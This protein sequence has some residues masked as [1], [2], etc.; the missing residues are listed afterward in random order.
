MSIPTNL[1]LS[2]V[3]VGYKMARELPRTIRSLSPQ[4]Q[5]GIDAADY[6]IIVVDNGSPCPPDE[7]DVRQWS[8]NARLIV[9]E[10]ATASPVAAINRGLDEA[11]GAVIG[12]FIDGARMASPGLLSAALGA[13]QIHPRAVVGTLAFHLGPDVQMRSVHAGYDQLVEDAL[14]AQCRWEEDPYHLF[15]ISVFAGSSAQGWFTL[16]SETNALFLHRGHWRE[17]GG[18]DSRFI[19]PGGGLANLDIWE[20]LCS[21]PTARIIMLLGEA[22]FHQFHGGIATNNPQ[23]PWQIF[24]DEYVALRGKPFTPPQNDPLLVGRLPPAAKSSF[25]RSVAI[26]THTI[27]PHPRDPVARPCSIATGQRGFESCIPPELLAGIQNGVLHSR[28][29]DVPFLKSPFDIA[30]Y[31]QF[32][33]RKNFHT[34]IEIGSKFGGSALWFADLMSNHGRDNPRVVCV[35]IKPL[36]S[37]TDDRIIVLTGDA[38]NLKAC[39]TSDLLAGLRHPWLVVEDSSHFYEQSQATLEFFHDWLQP[40]DYIVVEDG[41]VTHLTEEIYRRYENGPNRAVSD[42]LLKYPA[43]YQL[44]TEICDFYGRNATYNPNGWLARV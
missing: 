8:A 27:P 36:A 37:Y 4:F 17:I 9:M 18:Y 28:Y 12:V 38:S 29:R 3:V 32:F 39:L 25:D 11:K 2:I 13:S 22:T 21:D 5:R 23:S 44:D 31:M 34:V 24:H 41:I 35:D 16:P 19:T 40:G 33:S 30:L 15:E 42:F 20:R 26:A 43:S 7:T 14:L 1:P 10:Q 6:E